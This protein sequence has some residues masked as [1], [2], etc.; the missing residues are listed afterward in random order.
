VLNGDGEFVDITPIRL[1]RNESFK[2]QSYGSFNEALDE[3]YTRV[4]VIEKAASDIEIDKLKREIERLDRMIES[5][6]KSLAEE[7]FKVRNNKRIGDALYAHIGEFQTLTSKFVADKQAGIGWK[8]TISNITAKKKADE[9]PWVFF[10][11]LDEK[12][13]SAN[14]CLEDLKF[15]LDLRR[16]V[17]ENAAMYYERNKR[18][19][20][21]WEGAKAALE[22]ARRKRAEIEAKTRQAEAL[23][24][25]KPAEAMEELLERKVKHKQWFE[26]FR[27]FTSS[28]GFLV[29][30]G[31]DATSNEVLVK[32]YTDE[33]DVVFHA[34]VAGA[35]FVVVKT[36][37]KMPTDQCLKEASEF[38]AAFSRGWREGFGSVDV[39]WV[40][41]DQLKKS[42]QSG[43]YVSHGAFVVYGKRSWLRNTP[44]R[45]A[46]GALIGKEE[47]IRF[48]GGPVDSVK[49]KT[50]V[51]VVVVPG[52]MSGKELLKS[53]LAELAAKT[54]KEFQKQI[55]KTSVEEIREFVPYGTGRLFRS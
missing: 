21:K 34:D 11:S 37:G 46:V 38:A 29:V 13:Q 43:E 14:I 52:K 5:Q 27:W 7:E 24:K 44:L 8:E 36:E 17:Y 32:K 41:P 40:Y 10:E 19:K 26:K 22:E 49:P 35:P 54:S 25:I 50:N 42:G 3:F 9:K 23:Q 2:L 53:V 28:D 30:A 31:K 45:T 47:Q 55:L 4:S 33:K 51:F 15:G 20:Q 12:N 16:T 18:A 39:Y 6:E 48:V 1:K